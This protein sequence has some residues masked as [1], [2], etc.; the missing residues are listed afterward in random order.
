MKAHFSTAVRSLVQLAALS[1]LALGLSGPAHAV[2]GCKVLLCMAGNWQNI[3]QC[4]PTVRQALRDAALGR[5]WPSCSMSGD[6]DSGNEYV[7]PEQ[8]PEQYVTNTGHD[9]RGQPI[10]SCPFNGVIHVTVKG[11]P[12]SRTWW[13]P[14]GDAVIQWLP[15]ARAAFA[16][17]PNAMDDRYDREH[18]AWV[19]S[20]QARRAAAAAAAAQG[21]GG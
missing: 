21:S 11:R 7:V 1:G 20:E 14:S 6:S 19:I 10:Y 3:G 4:T 16:S 5:R 2:D 18:A 15:A 9:E 17:S 12:W 13:T 8:C